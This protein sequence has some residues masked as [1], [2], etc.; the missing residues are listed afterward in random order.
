MSVVHRVVRRPDTTLVTFGGA[1]EHTYKLSQRQVTQVEQQAGRALEFLSERELAATMQYLGIRSLPLSSADQA[2]LAAIRQQATPVAPPLVQPSAA[3]P[4]VPPAAEPP[5]YPYVEEPAGARWPLIFGLLALGIVLLGAVLAFIFLSRTGGLARATPTP[6]PGEPRAIAQRTTTAFAGPS[7]VYP[8]VG[9]LRA[10]EEAAILGVSA[11]RSWWLVQLPAAAGGQGWVSA[12]AVRAEN[13]DNVPIVPPP[14]LPTATPTLTPTATPTPQPTL[15]PPVAAVDGP[16]QAPAGQPLLFSGRRSAA[17]PGAIIV[18]YD[19]DFGDGSV[20]SGPEVTK[21]YDR[22]GVYTVR[23]TVLDDRGQQG[24]AALQ[25][26]VQP[27]TPV[28]PPTAIISGPAQVTA[29]ERVVFDGGASTGVN[30]IVGYFWEFGDGQVASGMRVEHVFDLPGTY[31]VVLTVQ[32]SAGATGV[33]GLVVRVSPPP[34][35]TPTATPLPTPTPTPSPAGLENVSWVLLDTLPGSTITALFRG[36]QV[37]GFAG[38]NNYIGSYQVDGDRLSISGLVAGQQSCAAEL[39]EQEQ[40]YLLQLGSAQ[41]YELQNG[42]LVIFIA[43][44]IQ[45]NTLTYVPAPR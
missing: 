36:G 3:V 5:E 4:P 29:G 7:D 26:V 30:P 19:W 38:C 20:A 45:P 12:A 11:D 18:R 9:E 16:S 13:A 33:A 41:R 21:V 39:L 40:R 25:V 42:Q 15:A 35:P 6:L 10:G 32:D 22:P 37:S 2:T 17:A 24:Q 1:P 44:P 23:L 28:P 31:T 34:T 14:P 27:P 43:G 8:A